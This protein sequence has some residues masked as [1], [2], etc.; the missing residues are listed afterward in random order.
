M[1]FDYESEYRV[2]LV[3]EHLGLEET[4]FLDAE[5]FKETIDKV[6]LS[7]KASQT[8]M[9]RLTSVIVNKYQIDK[10]IIDKSKLYDI[11]HFQNMY[12][13]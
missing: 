6:V 1:E 4:L 10:N 8:R 9:N 5:Y 3:A 7:P 12:G 13:L 11:Q 2:F